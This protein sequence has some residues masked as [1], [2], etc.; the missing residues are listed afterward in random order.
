MRSWRKRII[1]HIYCTT[2]DVFF[3]PRKNEKGLLGKL[4]GGPQR[5]GHYY[6]Y[7]FKRRNAKGENKKG[8]H[9]PLRQHPFGSV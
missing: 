9:D 2:F 6:G 7:G 8:K 3:Q 1:S 5:E 4:D